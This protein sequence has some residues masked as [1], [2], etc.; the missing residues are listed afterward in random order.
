MAKILGI[1]AKIHFFAQVK[2]F[3]LTDA[4]QQGLVE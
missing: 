3:S 4:Y 1:P 2:A